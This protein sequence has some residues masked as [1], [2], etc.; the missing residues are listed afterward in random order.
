MGLKMKKWFIRISFLLI[1]IPMVIAAVIY[2]GFRASLPTLEG[3]INAENLAAPVTLER[4]GNG[5]AT[6]TANNRTDLSYVAGFLHAQERFFQMDLSRRL[7]A[8][9]LSELFGALA[10]NADRENRVHRFRSRASI[11]I[12]LL[13]DF[14][15]L[16]LDRYAQGVNDG[17]AEL[18][19]KPFEYWLLGDEP[20]PW[21]P[22][23]SF[24]AIYAM[25]FTL[26]SSDGDFEWQNHLFRQSL[27]GELVDFLLPLRTE[28]DAPLQED[29]TK[30]VAEIPES[31]LLGV[32]PMSEITYDERPMLGSNNWAVSGNLSKTG[33]GMLSNDMHL[34]LRAPSIWYKFRLKLSDKSFDITGV[35]LPGVPA[36]VVGSNGHI[37]WGF[38]NSNIDHSDLIELKLNPENANQ[39]LTIDGYKDFSTIEETI[40][41]ADGPA[42]TMTVKETVWGPVITM[43]DSSEYAYRWVAHMPDGVNLE[44]LNFEK[45]KSV[46][47]AISLAGN[48]AIPAQNTVIV[49]KEGNIGWTLFGKLPM[50]PEGDYSTI[51]D[52]SDGRQVW[53]DWYPAEE[54]PRIVNPEHGRLWTANARALTGD[55][56][57]KVG[58]SHFDLGARAGQI[59]KRL[60]ELSYPVVEKDLYDIML[61]DEALFLARWQQ[62]LVEVLEATDEENFEP[63]LNE[64][65]NWGASADKESV[66]FRLVKEY[67]SQI[68]RTLMASAVRVCVSYNKECSYSRATK[69]WEQPLWQLVTTR[70][71]GWLPDGE[72]DWQFYFEQQAFEA[73]KP[74]M[75]GE[76]DLPDYTW[77]SR[78]ITNIAHPLSLAVPDIAEYIDMPAVEQSGDSENIPHITGLVEGQSIRMVVSPGYEKDGIM[79]LPSGQSGHPLSPYFGAG[80]QDWV[81]GNMT[82]FLPGETKWSL[83]FIPEK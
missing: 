17:L 32:G 1:T 5:N 15:R 66:G 43:P 44:L 56:F 57:K 77:G 58:Y 64:V 83:E 72:T 48:M 19:S 35:S 2:F 55:D 23:D 20:K 30:D 14:E 33:A 26:Q 51:Q 60:F 65:K 16:Q 76:I 25:F 71:D 21:T 74:V 27:P 34:A 12:E 41:I 45:A 81:S 7:A 53:N 22:E 29:E 31:S 11:A 80:H 36:V 37:A 24:L 62:Q 3:T 10:L 70:P 4:D 42:E 79:D 46:S 38:T 40:S 69:Q 47:E 6:I 28:W 54:N 39:Y 8:G 13:S 73:W 78:N 75:T 49:D 63:F 68:F 18:G 61:D 52:W 9:E 59:K 50:R 82:P 67:R